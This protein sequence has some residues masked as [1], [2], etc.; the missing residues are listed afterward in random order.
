PPTTPPDDGA[1]ED[2]NALLVALH[3]AHVH[4]H[5]VARLEGRY[6]LSEL[7]G[8]DPVDQIHRYPPLASPNRLIYR[9][10]HSRSRMMAAAA[11]TKR[12]SHPVVPRT[13]SRIASIRPRTSAVSPHPVP[14]TSTTGRGSRA[15]RRRRSPNGTRPVPSRADVATRHG[16]A[17]ASRSTS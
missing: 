16:S 13:G 9:S 11:R 1:F 8:L 2:L 10:P 15:I 4:A 12:W 7:L 6:V 14:K 17:P 5:G 3:D